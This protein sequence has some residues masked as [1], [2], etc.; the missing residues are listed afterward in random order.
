MDDSGTAAGRRHGRSPEHDRCRCNGHNLRPGE[1][2]RHSPDEHRA[3]NHPGRAGYDSLR[4]DDAQQHHHR[5][6]AAEHHDRRDR[7]FDYHWREP[8]NPIHRIEYRWNDDD[9][10]NRVQH[11]RDNREF[12]YLE[13]MSSYSDHQRWHY[14]H[15]NRRCHHGYGHR[16]GNDSVQYGGHCNKR[17]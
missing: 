8:A 13:P 2:R 12:Q 7:P 3:A 5:N 11:D 15:R 16:C 4:D 1:R 9:S 10:R 17:K 14:R 6:H